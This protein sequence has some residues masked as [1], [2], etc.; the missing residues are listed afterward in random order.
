MC[1]CVCV[2]MS[3]RER[4]GLGYFCSEVHPPPF[5]LMD[6]MFQYQDF[7]STPLYLTMCVRVCVCVCVY[8]LQV[9]L[10]RTHSLTSLKRLQLFTREN[11]HRPV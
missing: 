10:H 9:P 4:L 11:M 7:S 8:I 6:E 3:V 2:C 5:P 1:V